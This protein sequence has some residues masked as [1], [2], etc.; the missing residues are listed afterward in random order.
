MST[1]SEET[2]AEIADQ[3]PVVT[4]RHARQRRAARVTSV[5]AVLAAVCFAV[6]CVSLSVGD[7]NIPVPDVV[8]TLFG[9]GDQASE[10]I[11]NELRLPRALTA[12]LTGAAF[13]LSGAIFQTLVRNPLA[14]PDLIGITQGASASAVICILGF[15]LSGFVVSVGAFAGALATALVIYLLAWRDGISGYRFVLIGIAMA[16]MLMSVISY[17]M[18]RAEVYDAQQ[19][20]VWLTGSL[21]A[22][23]WATVKIIAW[24]SAV[25]MPLAVLVGRGLQV[26]QMGDDAAKSLGH[27][28]ERSRLSLIVIAVALAAVA[29]AAAGPVVFVAFVAAPIARRLVGHNGLALVPA[30]L[31]GALV[32]LASDFV[33][34]HAFPGTQFPVGVVTGVVGAPY[35]L[36]LLVTTNRVGRGG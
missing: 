6:F 13:G 34:Q 30:A 29:T 1:T 33:A 9:G 21:N 35:L 23:T 15:G 17:M 10:F 3:S 4:V 27:R 25:L 32:M 7:Y 36:W 28:V 12:V 5:T 2:Y 22:K 8:A 19:A 14:S 26:L 11:I 18:T 24:A 20:L 16:A 31:V